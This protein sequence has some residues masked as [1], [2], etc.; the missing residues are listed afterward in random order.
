M[1]LKY[2]KSEKVVIKNNINKLTCKLDVFLNFATFKA[3]VFPRLFV[4][5]KFSTAVNDS[6]SEILRAVLFVKSFI[7]VG[8]VS[9]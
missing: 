8:Y 6:K 1:D 2:E 9:F 7:C 4:K 3:K 5:L